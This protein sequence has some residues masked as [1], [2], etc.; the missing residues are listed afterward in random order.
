VI[1]TQPIGGLNLKTL[2]KN[3]PKPK[4]PV[5]NESQSLDLGAQLGATPF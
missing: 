3:K 4:P 2:A 1:S 5:D